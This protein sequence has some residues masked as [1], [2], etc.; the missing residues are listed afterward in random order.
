MKTLLN[1]FNSR[2]EKRAFAIWSEPCENED[3]AK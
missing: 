3:L 2:A 1:E